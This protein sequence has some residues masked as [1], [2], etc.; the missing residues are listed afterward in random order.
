MALTI[1]TGMSLPVTAQ[2][3]YYYR[4]C[5]NGE[6]AGFSTVYRWIDYCYYNYNIHICN[7][8]PGT[9]IQEIWWAGYILSTVNISCGGIPCGR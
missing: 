2:S 6:L 4:T 3:G 9:A 7:C 8:T 1:A 5:V